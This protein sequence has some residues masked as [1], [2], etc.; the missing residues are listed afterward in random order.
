MNKIPAIAKWFCRDSLL[1]MAWGI[2]LV[3]MGRATE[4][5]Q[6]KWAF[7]T[8]GGIDSC[9]AIGTD[10]TVYVGSF[11]RNFYALDGATGAKKWVFATGYGVFSSPAISVDGTV[12]V[13]AGGGVVYAIDGATGTMKW[14]FA[15]G[16]WGISS[17][18]I[19][20]DG[21]VYIGVGDGSV[22]AIDD[23]TGTMKWRTGIGMGVPSS[24]AVGADGTVYIGAG[25]NIVCA[26]DGATG[27]RK[28]GFG[29][30]MGVPSSP[31]IGPEGTVY[32]GTGGGSVCAL[33]GATG[34]RKW[35][36]WVGIQTYSSPAIDADGAVY[37]GGG[38]N[39]C[40]IDATTGA[41]KWMFATRYAIY[42]SPAV[43]AD[44]TVYFGVGDG[45][46]YALDGATGTKKWSFAT[47]GSVR[48]SPAIGTDGTVYIG[49]NDGKVYALQGSSGLA[50]SFWPKFRQNAQNGGGLPQASKV[51]RQPSRVVFEEGSIG[52][53]TVKVNGNPAPSVTWF[54]NG[55]P[56]TSATRSSLMIPSVTRAS[57]GLYTL[58]ASNALGQV[59][60][61]PII[62]LV[63]NVKP[64]QWMGLKW[65]GGTN[66]PVTLECTAQWVPSAFWHSLG[67]YPPNGST[68]TYVEMNPFTTASF[69]RLRSAEALRI[70]NAG[71]VNGWSIAEP[72]GS[73]ILVEVVSEASGW[74]RWQVLTNL[75]LPASPYLF[76][77]LLSLTAPE[78]VYRT[79]LVP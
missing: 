7:D 74:T 28:W 55:R 53:L 31:A 2:V 56:I 44:G 57:E 39:F 37:I 29:T 77:D 48:S 71:L 36:P 16:F 60:T 63:S 70:S 5:G 18:A 73:R 14:T 65:E 26:L 58:V 54:H 24:P 45:S 62:A 23:A 42:S 22:Y 64:Q 67:D 30:R 46:F 32:V 17:P 10:G 8:G 6:L 59:T 33:D 40:A 78:R 35:G 43:G 4:V 72:V 41:V 49:S 34:A 20:V 21:T 19:G 12:Y 79:T 25:D 13:G 66:G 52:K 38:N 11:G 51:L 27:T 9:P 47:G 69:Y 75:T 1:S 61:K 15:T 76:L 3:V 50:N 68:Q